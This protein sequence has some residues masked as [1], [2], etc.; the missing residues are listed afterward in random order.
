MHASNLPSPIERGLIAAPRVVTCDPLRPGLLGVIEDGAVLLERGRIVAV[1]RLD[2]LRQSGAP[3]VLR[4]EGVLT[5]GLV[6]AHT[7]A[8]WA[9]SR[10]DEYR[11]RLAGGDYEAIARA[12]GGIRSTMHAVRAATQNELEQR[13]WR[14]LHRMLA[15]GVTTVE[16]KSGYGLDEA[17]E[18]KQLQA[19]S[20]ARAAADLPRVVPTYLALHALPPEFD[21]RRGDFVAAVLPWLRAIAADGLASFVDAYVDRSAFS[22]DEAEPA[23]RLARELGLGVRVHAGQF[24]DV[25]AC[26]M[27]ARL[28]AA[29]ADHLEHADA[30]SIEALAAGHVAAVLL[31]VA[32][33][34]LGQAPPPVEA[35]RGAG[36]PLVVASDANPGTAPTESLPLALALAARSYGLSPAECILGATP[37]PA[38]ASPARPGC[39]R[40]G[41]WRIWCSGIS[42]TRTR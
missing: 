40:R 23:L 3:L 1:D 27:A 18:R 16:V 25:G 9:G 7:H 24:A 28:G 29:S 36:V 19:A 38:W 8:A 20:F 30:A 4:G 35:L 13:L 17:N 15:Q 37:P 34:T 12:G 2:V 26:Q 39:W 21:G 42:P 5:P 31:P 32:S 41:P 6:D 11:I 22:V 33:F 10:H 14:R